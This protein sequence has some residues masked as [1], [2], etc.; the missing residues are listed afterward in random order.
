MSLGKLPKPTEARLFNALDCTPE[1]RL[2][3]SDGRHYMP[4][5]DSCPVMAVPFSLPEKFAL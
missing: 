3:I 2:P 4:N 5:L 1:I